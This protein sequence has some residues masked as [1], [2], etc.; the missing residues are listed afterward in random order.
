MIWLKS[1]DAAM[2]E[3]PEEIDSSSLENAA[4]WSNAR[5]PQKQFSSGLQFMR[6]KMA[7]SIPGWFFCRS[8]PML[9]LAENSFAHP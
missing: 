8:T 5:T 3:R 2:L 6:G 9:S 1:S 7:K 4:L